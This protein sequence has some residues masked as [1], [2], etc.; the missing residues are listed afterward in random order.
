MRSVLFVAVAALV[1]GCG[2]P[3]N[4]TARELPPDHGELV[5]GIDFRLAFADPDQDGV[6]DITLDVMAQDANKTAAYGWTGGLDVQ[7]LRC[8][9]M[10]CNVTPET[11][12]TLHDDVAVERFTKADGGWVLHYGFEPGQAPTGHYQMTVWAKVAKTGAWLSAIQQFDYER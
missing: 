8:V 1:S 2:A 3:G 7:V 12:F 5:A 11:D 9:D 6:T 10:G 4:A